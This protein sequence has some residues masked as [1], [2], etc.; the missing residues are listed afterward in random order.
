MS[1][2]LEDPR[3]ELASNCPMH[4]AKGPRKVL[5]PFSALSSALP[6][7]P[8]TPWPPRIAESDLEDGVSF[9]KLKSGSIHTSPQTS[10]AARARARPFCSWG[11]TGS[12]VEFA[13]SPSGRRAQK[14]RPLAV[15]RCASPHLARTC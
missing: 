14:A 8:P 5:L 12:H 10:R 3:D 6:G 2:A 4:S 1:S 15:A 7:S 9:R 11:S 13:P